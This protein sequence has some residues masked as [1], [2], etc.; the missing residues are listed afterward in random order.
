MPVV[1][2]TSET[3]G[4]RIAIQGQLGKKNETLSEKQPKGKGPGTWLK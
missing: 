1:P 3:K 4:R 2:A